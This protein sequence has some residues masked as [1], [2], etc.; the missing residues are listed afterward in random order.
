[1]YFF[2]V[3]FKYILAG[4]F[5]SLVLYFDYVQYTIMSDLIETVEPVKYSA[6][7]NPALTFTSRW[8]SRAG[9]KQNNQ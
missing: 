7:V 4:L 8:M 1:M 9:K 2:V 6:N 5:I 3:V